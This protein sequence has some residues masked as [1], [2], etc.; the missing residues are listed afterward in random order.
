MVLNWPDGGKLFLM[1]VVP[2]GC[3]HRP[4]GVGQ[5]IFYN[6]NIRKN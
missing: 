2:L 4:Y 5:H 6:V 1:P 3:L